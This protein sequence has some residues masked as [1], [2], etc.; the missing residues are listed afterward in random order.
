MIQIQKDKDKILLSITTQL[1]REDVY[2]LVSDLNKWLDETVELPK[3]KGL[4]EDKVR[5]AWNYSAPSG[6]I[7]D[8]TGWS[9]E[10]KEAYHQALSKRRW[11]DTQKWS[12]EAPSTVYVSKEVTTFQ[13][14][15]IERSVEIKKQK[16]K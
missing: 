10:K 1:D 15:P 5:D 2:E 11:E 16:L 4:S 6:A 8:T 3:F 9:K 14:D 13:L 12:V 7:L